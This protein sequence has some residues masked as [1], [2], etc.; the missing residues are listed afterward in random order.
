MS[1]REFKPAWWCPG[2]HAQTI[3]GGLLRPYPRLRLKRKRLETSDGDFLD[4]DFLEASNHEAPLVLIV[5]GLEGSSHSPYVR[6]LLGVIQKKGWSAAALNMRMCSGEPNRT[7]T[8]YHSG[9]SEDLDFTIRFLKSSGIQKIYAVGYSLGGNVL[10]KWLGELGSKARDLVQ[11]TAAVSVPFDLVRTAELMDLG[12]NREVYTRKLLYG[13]KRKVAIKKKKFPNIM[14]YEAL[15]KCKTFRVFDREAT[16][17]LNGFQ[18]EMDYWTRSSSLFFLKII[19]V[20]TLIVHAEDDPFYGGD[21]L[22]NVSIE[23]SDSIEIRLSPSGG[24]IGFVTG[25]WPWRQEPW[26]ENQILEY[27]HEDGP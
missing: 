20:P 3:V 18:D 23:K 6:S 4:L 27:F 24:H 22:K 26:L 16:A 19:Q 11:K 9:K 10:L 15:K 17:R 2:A 1:A 7:P 12:F 21:C 8:T 14:N 13:L 5:H 25:P